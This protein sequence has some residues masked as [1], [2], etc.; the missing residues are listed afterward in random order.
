MTLSVIVGQLSDPH[1]QSVIRHVDG[2]VVVFDAASLSDFPFEFYESALTL[3]D[4]KGRAVTISPGQHA[5]GWIRRISPADWMTGVPGESQEAAIKASWIT[6]LT[7]VI[8]TSGVQ[9]LSDIDQIVRAENKLVVDAC[10]RRLKVPMP[11]TVVSNRVDPVQAHL[12]DV[13]IAKTLGPGHYI[14]VDG[15]YTVFAQA[16]SSRDLSHVDIAIAPF[17]F[18]ERLQALRHL[19]IVTVADSVWGAALENQGLPDD[20]RAQPE[21]HHSFEAVR[22]DSAVQRMASSIA[23]DLSLGYTSQDWIET[24]DG[25]FLLDVNPGGQWMF[26]PTPSADAASR[27]I[28]RWL[29]E[30]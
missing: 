13:A 14:G 1:V 7:A 3:P 9:W 2:Q 27:E 24:I 26:L 4:T 15:A 19:R 11:R 10:A 29:S 8:R 21:A 12:G 22:L 23:S 17:M 16:V 18:Q 28:A 6:L 30:R 20:W 25:F 5:R